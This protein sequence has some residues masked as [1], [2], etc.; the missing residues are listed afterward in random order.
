LDLP[1][2]EPRA[3][4]RMDSVEHIPELQEVGRA[5]GEQVDMAHFEGFLQ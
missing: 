1:H 5:V 4:Q 3:V 2:I